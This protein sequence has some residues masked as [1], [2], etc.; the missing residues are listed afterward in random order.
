MIR[1]QEL[2]FDDSGQKRKSQSKIIRDLT[3]LTLTYAA[4]VMRNSVVGW[5]ISLVGGNFRR[6]IVI[7]AVA[8]IVVVRIRLLVLRE[9]VQTHAL[10]HRVHLHPHAKQHDLS[11]SGR[12]GGRRRL[13]GAGYRVLDVVSRVWTEAQHPPT[14]RMQKKNGEDSAYRGKVCIYRR[15]GK[16][17]VW[18]MEIR[19]YRE[20]GSQVW[21]VN[22]GK[23]MW[24]SVTL[25]F[26]KKTWPPYAG[27]FIRFFFNFF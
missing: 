2:T 6:V 19:K 21:W 20:S 11:S 10:P 26:E 9:I 23:Y 4:G 7:S 25:S 16:R 8:I 15:E 13:A 22:K 14:C 1:K 18:R 17:G 27:R 24:R 3:S 5:G 12:H